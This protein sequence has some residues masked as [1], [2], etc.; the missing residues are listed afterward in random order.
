MCRKHHGAMFAT[1]LCAPHTGFRWT[2][3]EDRIAVYRSSD[4]GHRPFCKLCGSVAPMVMLKMGLVFL[5]A[6]NLD[7]DPGIRPQM[8]IFTGSR[9]DWFPITDVLPQHAAYP[10]QFG[11]GTGV[12]RRA[13][14]LK[15]G[16]TQGSCVC[17]EV[18][19]E[20]SGRPERMQNCHC[21]RCRRARSAAH[22]TNAFYQKDQLAWT[23]GQER[24]ISYA[25]PGAK[26]FGQAF[27]DQCGGKVPRVVESTGYVVVP[28]GSLDDPPGRFP[29]QPLPEVYQWRLRCVALPPSFPG[30]QSVHGTLFRFRPAARVFSCQE[31]VRAFSCQGSVQG[32]SEGGW[33]ETPCSFEKQVP[34]DWRLSR[35]P[36]ESQ[37][38]DW[39]P[40]GLPCRHNRPEPL[41]LAR[42]VKNQEN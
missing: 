6:G 1:F 23:R 7:S 38:E 14:A 35:V 37:L 26:R 40:G 10:P 16:V 22:A 29:R 4:N 5:L 20:L 13:P 25:L 30:G 39:Q 11:G 2:S 31:S 3:G 36:T 18:A 8:H 12:D 27:C 17:G 34:R 41:S 24:V 42:G 28:C 32:F 33:Q 9:A 21:S 15:P 19:W